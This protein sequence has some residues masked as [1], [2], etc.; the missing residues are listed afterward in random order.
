ML[1][2]TQAQYSTNYDIKCYKFK[3]M[4]FIFVATI[5]MPMAN[6]VYQGNLHSKVSSGYPMHDAMIASGLNKKNPRYDC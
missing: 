2:I 1:P 6:L 3:F 4:C 5:S